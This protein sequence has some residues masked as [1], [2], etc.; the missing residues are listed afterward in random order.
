M[1]QDI[2]PYTFNNSFKP[3][4]QINEEDYIFCFQGNKL[5]MKKNE[6]EPQLPQKKDFGN[7]IQKG[8]YLF[9]MNE[10]PCFL[11]HADF[12]SETK[13]FVYHEITSYRSLYRKEND[14]ITLLAYQLKNW[15]EQHRF[16]GTCGSKTKLKQDERAVECPVCKTIVYPTISPAIIVAIISNDKILLARGTN[17]R[18]DF[19]SLVAGYVDVG[20]SLEEAVVREVKEEVGLDIQNIRYYKSQPW[21]FSG[22]MMI[23]FIANA[24]ENQPIQ[25]DNKEIVHAA[26]FSAKDL[27]NHPPDRSIAGEMINK[28][29]KGEI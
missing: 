29:I 9:S 25:I 12:E 21:S 10:V 6:E 26:W 1:I 27:P 11:V 22:S 13:K 3:I 14:W 15:Y 7:K 8:I 28:F 24:N 19:Y 23:G 2:A 17:F 5:L 20:E 4:T 16:C 18:N